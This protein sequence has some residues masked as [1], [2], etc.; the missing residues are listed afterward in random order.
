LFDTNIDLEHVTCCA[1]HVNNFHF[2]FNFVQLIRSWFTTFFT[3]DTLRDHDL[4]PFDLQRSRCIRWSNSVLYRWAKSNNQRPS[5]S[6]L[7]I[8]N[9]SGAI[10][11]LIGSGFSEFGGL[12]GLTMYRHTKCSE[13]RQSANELLMTEFSHIV[14]HKNSFRGPNYTQIWAGHKPIIGAL[15]LQTQ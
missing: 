14:C 13:I 9:I 11:H 8:K 3:A 12:R 2:K 15:E 7:I 10:R 6:D 5:Y 4:S 1:T